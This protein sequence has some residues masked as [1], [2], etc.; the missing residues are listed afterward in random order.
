MGYL[1]PYRGWSREDVGG[2]LG[3]RSEVDRKKCEY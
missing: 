3:T 2:I 1:L